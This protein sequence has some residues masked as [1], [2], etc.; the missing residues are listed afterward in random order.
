MGVVTWDLHLY[1]LRDRVSDQISDTRIWIGH[2]RSGY[3]GHR[4]QVIACL[5]TL[6]HWRAGPQR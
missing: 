1:K 5:H 6:A 2:L 4:G 3:K